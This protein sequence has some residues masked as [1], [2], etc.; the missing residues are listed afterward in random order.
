MGDCEE[1]LRAPKPGQAAANQPSITLGTETTPLLQAAAGLRVAVL[2]FEG[3]AASADLG[4]G[5]AEVVSGELAN[6]QGIVVV[7]RAAINAV[8]KEMEIQRSGLTDAD[9]VR[10]GRGLNAKKM[11]LGSVRRF[12]EDT[13]LLTV[14]VVDVE[15][16]RVEG[17]RDVTCTRCREQDILTAAKELRKLIVR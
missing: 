5:V 8:L 4:E 15:T 13:F 16:Q 6:A 17:Q 3:S 11:V 1:Y 7:E 2:R 12:G 14:R 10:I 9:A